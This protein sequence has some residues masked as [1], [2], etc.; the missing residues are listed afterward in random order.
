MNPAFANSFDYLR[1][2]IVSST[3][4][5][6]H[7]GLFFIGRVSRKVVPPLLSSR[8][9]P[10]P[11]PGELCQAQSSATPQSF[12]FGSDRPLFGFELVFPFS[13][14]TPLQSPFPFSLFPGPAFAHRGELS[15]KPL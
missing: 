4:S 14:V 7:S 2:M 12:F 15:S 5:G 6:F 1:S 9:T 3:K 11:L 13:G 8:H 10:Y